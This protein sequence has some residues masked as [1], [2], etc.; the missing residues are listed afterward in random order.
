MLR[1]KINNYYWYHSC[2]FHCPGVAIFSSNI[3]KSIYSIL[4]TLTGDI[5]MMNM[6]SMSRKHN[7]NSYGILIF[8]RLNTFYLAMV[9][10]ELLPDLITIVATWD[11]S[12]NKKKSFNSCLVF[13]VLVRQVNLISRLE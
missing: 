2:K 4:I 3:Y 12:L 13:V 9:N 11:N 6:L 5:D 1:P 8:V 7:N 10:Y